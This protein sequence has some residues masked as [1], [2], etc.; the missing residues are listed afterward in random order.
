M[1]GWLKS[2]IEVMFGLGLFINVTLFI[3]QIISLPKTKN[4]E[5]VSLVAFFEN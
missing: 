2:F 1:S 4:A 5:G 3:P